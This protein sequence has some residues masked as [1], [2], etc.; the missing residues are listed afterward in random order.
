MTTKSSQDPSRS[1]RP[2][3]RR[4][5]APCRVP[6]RRSASIFPS[7]PARSP[8]AGEPSWPSHRP[9]GGPGEAAGR[10]ASVTLVAAAW[11]LPFPTFA[12]CSSADRSFTSAACETGSRSSCHESGQR[13]PPVIGLAS[14]PQCRLVT[15]A[16]QP[17]GSQANRPN[18]RPCGRSHPGEMHD[19]V[20][21]RPVDTWMVAV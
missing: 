3:A 6:T 14:R 8:A 9:N 10:D 1:L 21:R 15:A 17:A 12:R 18:V 7:P 19:Q 2:A 13:V 4:Q 20:R 11:W 5:V 16:S